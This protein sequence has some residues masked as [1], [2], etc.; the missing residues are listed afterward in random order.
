MQAYNKNRLRTEL[1]V[2]SLEGKTLLSGGLLAHHVSQSAMAAPF[3]AQATTAFS[4]TL[5]G[6]Y[7]D[8]NA[9]GFAHIQNYRTF[10]NLSGIGP[11]RLRGTLFI[12]PNAPAG[13]VDG[14]FVMRNHGGMMIIKVFQSATPGHYT[15]KVVRA[16]GSDAL[17]RGDTGALTI[18]QNP[19]FS[20]PFF[21]S[22]EATMT[23]SS[24]M[25]SYQ[26]R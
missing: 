9:P 5:M 1:R 4:G 3:V 8:I 20:V 22:G 18:T 23:F 14:S 10:G 21:T 26:L 16:R 24:G 7:S 12:R 19:T 2:E 15:Y 6:M 13:R 11:T 25:P 17:F